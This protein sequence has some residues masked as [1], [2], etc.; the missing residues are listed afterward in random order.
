MF[1]SYVYVNRQQS[2]RGKIAY[3]LDSDLLVSV[4]EDYDRTAS[5]VYINP[6]EGL[7]VDDLYRECKPDD[8]VV[9]VVYVAELDSKEFEVGR[10]E[11]LEMS[12]GQRFDY[13]FHSDVDIMSVPESQLK[14]R[15]QI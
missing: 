15:T 7:T 1:E 11:A 12:K 10:D 2:K 6:D 8:G 5:E 13:L 3:D 4:I 9:G 14:F